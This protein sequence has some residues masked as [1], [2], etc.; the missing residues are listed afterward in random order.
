LVKNIK[1]TEKEISIENVVGSFK[2]KGKL[3]LREINDK[4]KEDS[5]FNEQTFNYGVVVLKIKKPKM[6]FLIY[7]TGKVICA[8][9]KSVESTKNSAKIILNLFRKAGLNNTLSA[10]V[11]IN[12][13]VATGNIEEKINLNL[14]SENNFNIDYEPE[15]FPGAIYRSK[16]PRGTIL[17]FSSGKIVCT[18][19]KEVKDI[20]KTIDAFVDHIAR[21]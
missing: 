13:I 1:L 18:G 2:L 12:N 15:S 20:L 5:V 21:T 7:R 19:F 10:D 4:F 8:G 16:D 9:A 11:V 17:F 14:V 6:S 3:D